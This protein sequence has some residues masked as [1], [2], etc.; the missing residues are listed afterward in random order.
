M[1]EEIRC[2]AGGAVFHGGKVFL[3]READGAWA[4]PKGVIRDHMPSNRVA[5]WR[6]EDEAGIQAP[7]IL[8]AAGYTFYRLY[9]KS[10][11]REVMNRIQWFAMKS[12]SG[13]YRVNR[14]QGFL[15]G[16]W[17][18][19]DEAEEM[20]SRPMDVEILRKAALILRTVEEKAG[21]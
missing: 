11:D 2:C 8:G 19:P 7:V 21:D 5:R 4:M 12:E 13:E 17:Y 18:D 10:R 20:L 9:S 16:G 15:D 6:V 3:I 1:L 14:E